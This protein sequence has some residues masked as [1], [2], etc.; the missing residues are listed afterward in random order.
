MKAV[1]YEDRLIG[2][3]KCEWNKFEQKRSIEFSMNN[4]RQ[5]YE[6]FT[7][8]YF[9]PIDSTLSCLV[10]RCHKTKPK[11][12]TSYLLIGQSGSEN[13]K[14]HQKFAKRKR[15]VQNLKEQKSQNSQGKN[16]LKR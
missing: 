4:V 14:I 11:P 1:K 13:S 16:H 8:K 9:Q 6:L 5:L 2:L 3:N 7:C 12:I 15:L 10:S